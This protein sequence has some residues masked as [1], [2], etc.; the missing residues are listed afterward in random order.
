MADTVKK[1]AR[2][3]G[4]DRTKLASELTKKYSQGREHP[5][6]RRGDRAVLR[7]RPPDPHRERRHAA[8]PGWCDPRQG[9]ALTFPSGYRP[10]TRPPVLV[11]QPRER[12]SG[13]RTPPAGSGLR[14]GTVRPRPAR[15][16]CRS[17]RC[18][19]RP[20]ARTDARRTVVPRAAREAT[21]TCGRSRQTALPAPNGDRSTTMAGHQ[22]WVAIRSFSRDPTVAERKLAPGTWRRI[23]GYAR[24]YR[25]LDRGVPR[26]RRPRRALR[27]RH[28]AA[29]SSGSS[30]TASSRR[31]PRRSSSRCRCSSPGSPWST[32][33]PGSCS[34]G[35]RPGSA[36]ASST[37][38]APRCSGT[39][40][41]SRSRSSP[42]PRPARW[43]PG[44]TTT[45][46][47]PSRRSP[48]RCPGSSSNVVSLV[49]VDG[50]MLVPVLADH[51][52]RR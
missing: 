37:T 6:P 7:V 8:Q 22:A 48:R 44:S 45:S 13:H 2:I 49:L 43:S 47:A 23:L 34:D 15:T 29:A 33:S 40:C 21:G 10:S 9:Q 24:P 35:S 16:T 28:P 11:P 31:R 18:R 3:T 39:C 42:G 36:R 12:G 51:A 1:G 52:S 20:C 5:R 27:R 38:C 32:R 46:S 30:T 19:G 41:A 14:R 4:A 26:A 50:A 17:A 25:R